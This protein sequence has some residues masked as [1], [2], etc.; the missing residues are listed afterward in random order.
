[1]SDYRPP[2]DD[3]LEILL[4][5][6]HLLA[7]AKP[8][9]L[10]SVPGRGESKRDCLLSRVQS[11][12]PDAR[13]V[14]RL[15]MDTSGVMLFALDQATQSALGRQFQRR[16]V[17]KQYQAIV[18]GRPRARQ[19]EIAL[20]LITDW[21]RRPRQCVDFCNGKAAYTCYRW[22]A[23]G[24]INGTSRLL[25]QPLTGRSHQ[26]RVHLAEIGH[27]ILGD[28]LYAAARWREAAPRMWLHAHVLRF[29]D[30]LQGTELEIISPAAF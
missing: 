28:P 15:D 16:R 20:P 8:A 19:G 25:L 10:L 5:L 27:P 9:G 22:L 14:H 18:A 7:V 21:P 2:P 12:F 6:P 30:P 29:P 3:G 23:D 24:P 17:Y 26:L 13:M 4:Q 1:M 11:R